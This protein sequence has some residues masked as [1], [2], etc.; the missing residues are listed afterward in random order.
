MSFKDRSVNSSGRK[1]KKQDPSNIVCSLPWCVWILSKATSPKKL[2]SLT[3]CRWILPV[4]TC[5]KKLFITYLST[6]NLIHRKTQG[7]LL[8]G[9]GRRKQ[10]CDLSGPWKNWKVAAAFSIMSLYIYTYDFRP[11]KPNV[12]EMYPGHTHTTNTKWGFLTKVMLR[13]QKHDTH[14][15]LWMVQCIRPKATH[16]THHA[17]LGIFIFDRS[18]PWNSSTHHLK[19]IWWSA[20]PMIQKGVQ[21]TKTK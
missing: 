13:N 18:G 4:S 5:P 21:A 10:L 8:G 15:S 1:A 11:R 17:A 2:Y 7:H 19:Y 3:W 12:G 6:I 9:F 14:H 16:A 20:I